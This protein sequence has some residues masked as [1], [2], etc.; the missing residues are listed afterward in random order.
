MARRFRPA[1]AVDLRR[2]K[3]DEPRYRA[4]TQA[5]IEG[6]QAYQDK[7]LVPVHSSLAYWFSLPR[8]GSLWT[9]SG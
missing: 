6:M 8:L 1:D 3:G 7:T 4:T 9:R 5:A 2:E